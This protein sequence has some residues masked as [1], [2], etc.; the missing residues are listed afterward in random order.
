LPQYGSSPATAAAAR[1]VSVVSA[2]E[3]IAGSLYRI[4]RRVVDPPPRPPFS[5][6]ARGRALQREEAEQREQAGR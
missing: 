3:S 6:T 5:L 4:A 2:E 1:D